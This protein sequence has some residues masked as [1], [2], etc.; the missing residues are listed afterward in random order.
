MKKC[1]LWGTGVCFNENLNMVRY[2]EMM[3]HFEVIGVTSDAAFYSE[4]RGY[5]YIGKEALSKAGF[6]FVIILA[7]GKAFETIYQEALSMEIEDEKIFSYRVLTYEKFN[8]DNYMEL[9]KRPPSIFANNCWGGFTYHS[10]GLKFTSPFIN[11]FVH[12]SDYLKLLETP[13]AYMSEKLEL[14]EMGYNDALKREYPIV[15]CGD[16]R[17][18]FNHYVSFEEACR[19]WERRKKRIDWDNLFVMM[20]TKDYQE[21]NRFSKLPYKKKV[22]FV[23]FETKEKSLAYIDISKMQGMEFWQIINDMASGKLS[24][25]DVFTLLEEGNMTLISKI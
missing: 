21:A 7:T 9:K 17:L 3:K 16:V 13:K 12:N 6:D 10:L 2:H 20:Y 23:P 1:I 15:K 19:C 8:V 11:M 24:Y 25:Y 5:R 14:L 4:V 22:C 18:F